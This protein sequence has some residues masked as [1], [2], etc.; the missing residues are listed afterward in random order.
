VAGFPWYR[1]AAGRESGGI[2]K[3]SL[4]I[5]DFLI[6]RLLFARLRLGQRQRC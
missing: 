1:A 6:E 3:T 4:F 2:Q 5:A